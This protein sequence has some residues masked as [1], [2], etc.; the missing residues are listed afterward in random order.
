[1]QNKEL[2]DFAKSQFILLH[3]ETSIEI[4]IITCKEKEK[5]LNRKYYNTER[6]KSRDFRD[7]DKS[8]Y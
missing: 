4:V 1:M 3:P 5:F 7:R 8:K 2:K 6:N